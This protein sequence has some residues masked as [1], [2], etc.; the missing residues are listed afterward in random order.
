MA[1]L[2][3]PQLQWRQ[4]RGRVAPFLVLL[5]V[6]AQLRGQ[7]IQLTHPAFWLTWLAAGCCLCEP[8]GTR[9]LGLWDWV[10]WGA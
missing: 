9:L 4:G 7:L 5:E 8:G 2:E 10:C 3:L 1:R 6:S